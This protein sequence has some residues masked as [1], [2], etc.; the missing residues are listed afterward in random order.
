MYITK[1]VEI[2]SYARSWYLLIHLEDDTGK[3]IR[4]YEFKYDHIPDE[5]EVKEAEALAVRLVEE[6]LAEPL[7]EEVWP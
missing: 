6:E 4:D 2:R 3:I 7:P 5:A 1:P